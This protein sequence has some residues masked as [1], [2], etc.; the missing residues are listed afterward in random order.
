M[1]PFLDKNDIL[2]VAQQRGLCSVIHR[3]ICAEIHRKNEVSSRHQDSHSVPCTPPLPLKQPQKQSFST[4]RLFHAFGIY[5]TAYKDGHKIFFPLEHK[6][7]T[8]PSSFSRHT[9]LTSSPELLPRYSCEIQPVKQVDNDT[10]KQH[11]WHG[12]RHQEKQPDE[13][14]TSLRKYSLPRKDW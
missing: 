8:L 1:L 2:C 13:E 9:Q 12:K 5:H 11:T 7:P 3:E 10:K 4:R 6:C 14:N